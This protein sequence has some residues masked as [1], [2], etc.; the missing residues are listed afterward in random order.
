M[1]K[2]LWLAL[3]PSLVFAQKNIILSM[4]KDPVYVD[5]QSR[6]LIIYPDRQKI[7]ATELETP[8]NRFERL[9]DALHETR[10]TRYV[11]LLL[12]PDSASLQR[13]LRAALR[14]HEIEVGLEPWKPGTEIIPAE[15]NQYYIPLMPAYGLRIAPPEEVK[16]GY[17]W[18]ARNG[19]CEVVVHSNVVVFLTNN[20]V[21]SRADLQIPGNAFDRMLDQWDAGEPFP[22]YFCKEPGGEDLYDLIMDRIIERG[23]KKNGWT[24]PGLPIEVPA[25]GRTPFYLECRSNQLFTV[26]ADASPEVFD[27]TQLASFDSKS[28]FICFLV[29]PDSFEI[30]RKART[31]AWEQ[32]L[33][34]SCELQDES[35][36]LT[37]GL[38]GHLL[39]PERT[40]P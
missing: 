18:L 29:R 23:S 8:G 31:A 1:K 27:I 39:F 6:Q 40:A 24:L 3:I 5:V 9:L 14:R 20:V 30:F 35:G 26:S 19:H 25:N 32:Y 11:I 38:D 34:V 28:Q 7:S 22:R 21:V 17:E 33:G 37:I 4:G 10:N 36:P 15:M 12:A 13:Q 2:W 16:F